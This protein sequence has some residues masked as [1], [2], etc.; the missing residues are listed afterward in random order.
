MARFSANSL[1]YGKNGHMHRINHS[2]QF[3][4]TPSFSTLSARIRLKANIHS[5]KATSCRYISNIPTTVVE[6]PVVIRNISHANPKV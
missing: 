2:S 3:E 4:K 6:Y 5:E 1:F